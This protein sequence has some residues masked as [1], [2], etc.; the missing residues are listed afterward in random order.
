MGP[1]AGNGLVISG[2]RR[3]LLDQQLAPLHDEVH[4]DNYRSVWCLIGAVLVSLGAVTAVAVLGLAAAVMLGVVGAVF[5]CGIAWVAHEQG[6]VVSGSFRQ[7]HRVAILG[8]VV[9]LGAIG[10]ITLLGIPALELLV[11]LLA[12]SPWLLHRLTRQSARSTAP[13]GVA[14]DFDVPDG[15]VSLVDVLPLD[16]PK[17]PSLSDDELCWAWRRSYP[18]IDRA[19]H[20]QDF[21]RVAELRQRYLDELER[22]D[23]VGFRNWLEAGARAASDPARFM[24]YQS[25]AKRRPAA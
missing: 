18:L 17:V 20:P 19:R 24:S 5:A 13:A 8:A 10:L 23:P 6:R 11:L 1:S 14:D 12:T 16:D 9:L 3:D 15:S 7:L 25:R 4:M 22:R 2:P 21:L